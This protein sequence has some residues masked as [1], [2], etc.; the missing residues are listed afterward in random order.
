MDPL[1]I[2][3]DTLESASNIQSPG[4]DPS[5]GMPS[6]VPG[7]VRENTM[8]QLNQYFPNAKI[9]VPTAKPGIVGSTLSAIGSV[10][11]SAIDF[12]SDVLAN[13]GG[14]IPQP[15]KDIGS[16]T[17]SQIENTLNKP[18][19]FPDTPFFNSIHEIVNTGTKTMS[20][21]II[22]PTW[23]APEGLQRTIGDVL[24][25][26]GGFG[27]ALGGLK[28]GILGIASAPASIENFIK[29]YPIISNYLAGIGAFTAYG[30][31]DPR[32]GSDLGARLKQAAIDVPFGAVYEALPM[33]KDLGPKVTRF[34]IPVG[35]IASF[36]GAGGLG[37]GLAKMNG[38]SNRDA[39]IWGTTFGILDLVSP[40]NGAGHPGMT[41]E[42]SESLLAQSAREVLKKNGINIGEKYS[43][44]DLDI[45]RTDWFRNLKNTNPELYKGF[46]QGGGVGKNV[47]AGKTISSINSAFEMLKTVPDVKRVDPAVQQQR[48]QGTIMEELTRLFGKKAPE[49][50]VES[51][52][53]EAPTAESPI[54][55]LIE[56]PGGFSKKTDLVPVGSTMKVDGQEYLIPT[57][58]DL[59]GKAPSDVERIVNQR[60]GELQTKLNS[61]I[62]GETKA[63]INLRINVLSSLLE[64]IDPKPRQ[65]ITEM[66]QVPADG[67][68]HDEFTRIQNAIKETPPHTPEQMRALTNFSYT[69]PNLKGEIRE[70]TGRFD[71]ALFGDTLRNANPKLYRLMQSG[72][73]EQV[74]REEIQ[75][76]AVDAKEINNPVP[77]AEAAYSQHSTD[78]SYTALQKNAEDLNTKYDESAL[79]NKIKK[80]A[81]GEYYGR[82][83]YKESNGVGVAG[84][85]MSIY[86]D[87][88]KAGY[89]GFTGSKIGEFMIKEQFQRK[90]LAS[91]VI[92]D[93]AT[94]GI[95]I[96][97]YGYVKHFGPNADMEQ[98]IRKAGNKLPPYLRYT[99]SVE[100]GMEGISKIDLVGDPLANEN[101]P[102][103][104]HKI[105][106]ELK[107]LAEKAQKAKSS[108]KFAAEIRNEESKTARKEGDILL[109]KDKFPK[110][111][112]GGLKDDVKIGS[113]HLGGDHLFA[114]AFTNEKR[115]NKEKV[116][117]V[118]DE[119]TK[120]TNVDWKVDGVSKNIFHADLK[121]NPSMDK[122]LQEHGYG[123]LEEFHSFATAGE[124]LKPISGQMK[125]AL[126]DAGITDKSDQE[127]FVI[128]AKQNSKLSEDLT[129]KVLNRID[130]EVKS[131]VVAARYII[132]QANRPDVKGPE[133]DIIMEVL[134]EFPDDQVNVQDFK[135]KVQ[136]SLLPL[137]MIESNTYATYGGDNLGID[138]DNAEAK[139]HI[140]N[141]PFIHG[142]SGHFGGDF[143]TTKLELEVKQIPNTEKWAVVR[144]DVD[145]TEE[146]I[147]SGRY[148]VDVQSTKEAADKSLAQLDEGQG[149]NR[150]D[151]GLF[152]HSRVWKDGETRYIAEIQSDAFQDSHM[153]TESMRLNEQLK[154]AT[155]A[156]ENMLAG[157]DEI[158]Q[159]ILSRKEGDDIPNSLISK[160]ESHF[161]Y[162]RF[163]ADLSRSFRDMITHK[164][165]GGYALNMDP[166]E[167]ASLLDRAISFQGDIMDR[168]EEQIAKV[169]R[170]A[171]LTEKSF[172]SY[173]NRWHERIVKEEIH[174][175]ALSGDTSV[176]FPMPFT[177]AKIEGF[178]GN[179]E[180][181][182]M[183]YTVPGA[184]ETHPNDI[185][186]L[187]RGDTIKYGGNT[188][189]VIDTYDR[190]ITV[191]PEDEVHIFKVDELE[192]KK[193]EL[194]E[195]GMYIDEAYTSSYPKN[196]PRYDDLAYMVD[197]GSSVE[198][199]M[200]PDSYKTVDTEEDFNIDDLGDNQQ[201]VVKFYE[202]QVLPFVK[203]IRPGN[204]EMVYDTA[205]NSWLETKITP[206]DK[207]GIEAY[208]ISKDI[209]N[210]LFGG[211]VAEIIDKA[212]K[213]QMKNP[214]K[215][216]TSFSYREL[217]FGTK[218]DA[219]TLINKVREQVAK[220]PQGTYDENDVLILEDMIRNVPRE[221][222][223]GLDIEIMNALAKPTEYGISYK[224]LEGFW[225]NGVIGI[226]VDKRLNPA[227]FAHEFG[228]HYFDRFL[229]QNEKDV[230]FQAY[231]EA[232]KN[233]DLMTMLFGEGGKHDARYAASHYAN[234]AVEAGIPVETFMRNEFFARA[235]EA[236]TSK[237]T[238]EAV[239]NTVKGTGFE[240]FWNTLKAMFTRTMKTLF[241]VF[242]LVS[243]NT[244]TKVNDRLEKIFKKM[245]EPQ[246]E[247][248]NGEVIPGK[249][250]RNR[251][252]TGVDKMQRTNRSIMEKVGVDRLKDLER[253]REIISRQGGDTSI[254]DKRIDAVKKEAGIAAEPVMKPLVDTR[255]QTP[256]RPVVGEKVASGEKP[257]K[258]K[259][260]IP[261]KVSESIPKWKDKA[262]LSLN[263]E[264]LDR[265]I[266]DVAGEDAPYVKAFLSDPITINETARTSFITSLRND[267]HDTVVDNMGIRKGSKD[268][269][270]IQR[271]GEKRMTLEELK[272]ETKNWDNVQKA[273]GIFRG[274]YDSLLSMVNTER[275]K[276]GYE[277]IPQREDYFRHF[278]EIG[279]AIKEFG[280]LLHQQDIPTEISGLTG[281]FK[282]GKPFSNAEMQRK[283]G[284]FTESA[285]GGFDNY[286][287]SISRQIF[288]IDS[289]QRGRS[290]EKYIRE[291]SAR[292]NSIE[293]PNFV[294]NLMEMTNLVSG[295][296]AA[297]DRGFE[298]MFGRRFYGVMSF[299]KNRTAGNMIA[300]NISSA[301]TNYIP[302]TQSIAVTS[303]K[304]SLRALGPAMITY[305]DFTK[306]NG[307]TSGFVTRRFPTNEIDVTGFDNVKKTANWIFRVIDQ[308]VSR[309]VV[310]SRF[311]DNLEKGMTKDAAMNEAD[312]FASKII[313]DRSIGALPNL[314]GAKSLGI[315]TQFQTEINNQAS[316]IAKDIP[317]EAQGSKMRLISILAQ[318]ALYSYLF[319]Q[320]F[321]MI[322][323][324]RPA[325]DPIYAG[326]TLA[327]L[328]AEGKDQG[329]WE[330]VFTA[331]TDVLGNLPFTGGFTSGRYPI[332]AG[333]PNVLGLMQGKAQLI[334]ELEK[335]IAFLLM[336]V[337]GLQMKKSYEGMSAFIKGGAYNPSGNLKYPIKRDVE[338]FFKLLMFGQYATDESA[339][340]YNEKL[341]A[342]SENQSLLYKK[343]LET[344]RD[345]EALNLYNQAVKGQ[346]TNRIFSDLTKQVK[347]TQQPPSPDRM[348]NATEKL[349]EI[350]QKK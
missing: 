143:P 207:A 311:Y 63:N 15:I 94:D 61:G 337:G 102:E 27:G 155:K 268:D 46:T 290:L 127:D 67:Y 2:K 45:Q 257:I 187:S 11:K 291:S 65:I 103:Q 167:A 69:I 92:R 216:A 226:L 197:F 53:A 223:G 280:M 222:L 17:V 8:K 159:E 278:Q 186:D 10:G 128:Y 26:V 29:G 213:E 312:K 66:N 245:Y 306:I 73:H 119:L 204:W 287:D 305:G 342:L 71:P 316:F 194:E 100:P 314:F 117:S 322:T 126:D 173:K 18:G 136:A 229:N 208:K 202:K 252:L 79:Q 161:D 219:R 62:S 84:S 14:A 283:N 209:K 175:A 253:T 302:L 233:D 296:K 147:R 118:I 304:N 139:T 277:P 297:F 144:K 183:P 114:V 68:L 93:L 217:P 248:K 273:A 190:N 258:T 4:F 205:G 110:D 221:S 40:H 42:T 60:I 192:E 259:I 113:G 228:H 341:S 99:S 122:K 249:D 266:D 39:M 343:L 336:P 130:A 247:R 105:V 30:Q 289:V 34:N 172:L 89:I 145:L 288:H 116:Q 346:M 142:Y 6:Y 286:L 200:Q 308:F 347:E 193:A 1:Q 319:N 149:Y 87:G 134:K 131:P 263:R 254:I 88:E 285:I 115:L 284:P 16:E 295:K 132:D 232:I 310:S 95:T 230:V 220:L 234:A 160:M 83:E 74:A 335:P 327:G 331:T 90:G 267:L 260:P 269:Q 146:N 307:M 154:T 177:V 56:P 151:I 70:V 52:G 218:E 195:N 112:A 120:L 81:L 76:E 47:D 189:I 244:N 328:S 298:G 235:F 191:I 293:L 265:N 106:K 148:V 321:Q 201:T 210:A 169:G 23:Q 281:I 185:G 108:K 49:K 44:K 82:I 240:K 237:A 135:E 137:A 36:T 262:M 168:Y 85:G 282:P 51:K 22:Q 320:V 86:L 72:I 121:K 250:R 188:M 164:D 227:V 241:R 91:A 174:D 301:M 238:R 125:L 38:D 329:V 334:P 179:E 345:Q 299:I 176:R 182:D 324:R 133:R 59:A 41:K 32:L 129:T 214:P 255:K 344:G 7:G 43:D 300:M 184:E 181:G 348:Q 272:A 325:L 246:F 276:F 33:L 275:T 163:D 339:Q 9:N 19:L 318:Y 170:D 13:I 239:D 178:V 264:T 96:K 196:D 123:S 25:T 211:S 55:G 111:L 77:A 165:T 315:I 138:F 156:R 31:L 292:D 340:F 198:E 37:Y 5:S 78:E 64:R 224:N 54:S 294:A 107:P 75:Q 231:Q 330:R 109:S 350:L 203:K 158:K 157:R 199:F 243:K 101:K 215:P 35:S 270:L 326:L 309:F 20:G 313:A 21:N 152:A 57:G 166:H 104:N 171:T 212:K 323:G 50:I 338:S 251:K 225:K 162:A 349:A 236:Y 48:E 180:H 150:R 242:D 303:K 333:I 332:A 98:A 80:D 256:D 141:S 58:T 12:G 153:K 279:Y 206:E 3:K 274:Y 97:G 124:P 271:F 28:K 261:Q 140:Y 317:K 24:G